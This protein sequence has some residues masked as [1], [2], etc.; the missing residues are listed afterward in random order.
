MVDVKRQS[1]HGSRYSVVFP[2]F[3]SFNITPQ[4]AR[5]YQ[6][7]GHQDVLELTYPRFS[8]FY[9]KALKTGV[10]V[11]FT[12]Q[13]DKAKSEWFGY[14][15]DVKKNTNQSLNQPVVVRCI[16]SSLSTKEGGTK[17]WTHKTATDIV[18]DI[19]KKFKLKPIVTPHRMV[20]SQQSLSGQTYWEKIQELATRIGYAAHVTGTELHFHPLDV[21]I[22]KFM[23]TIPTMAYIDSALAPYASV[24]DQTLD[25]FRANLGDYSDMQEVSRKI[26]T[27]YGVD[28]LTAKLYSAKSSADT[29]GKNLKKDVK[30]PLFSQIVSSATTGSK[31]MAV[32]VADAQAQFSR[33]VHHATSAGQGHPLIAP[34]R[35]VEIKGTGEETDGFWITK[36]VQHFITFDGRYEVEF[37]CMTDGLGANK[38]SATRPSTAGNVPVRNVSQEL[39]TGAPST[40]AVSKISAPTSLVN[41][42]QSGFKVNPRRWVGI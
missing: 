34:Y 39:S 19:A 21:M 28:P 10:P 25:V 15:Y 26:K 12:W 3:P 20:F 23:T 5:L 32:V 38:S 35:A 18:T 13:N 9:V 17:I 2:D 31:E 16:S 11:K 36:K 37:S 4:N 27:I 30:E 24:M 14:V 42:T 29:V 7:I 1:R 8:S 41:Q 6:E 33:F 40:P 22:D